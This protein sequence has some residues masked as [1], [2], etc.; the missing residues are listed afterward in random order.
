MM[1]FIK[2]SVL[3]LLA[4]LIAV[5]STG[6]SDEQTAP[7]LYKQFKAAAAKSGAVAA[8]DKYQLLWDDNAKCILLNDV[9]TGTVWSSMPYDFYKK[10]DK[11]G[12]ALVKLASPLIIEYFETAAF[13][14]KTAAAYP[15]CISYNT[16]LAQKIKNG[17]RV[18]YYFERLEIS[19]PL[20]YILTENGLEVRLRVNDIAENKNLV[21]KV[22]VLPYFASASPSDE[23]YL[24]IPSGSGAL[25]Y[26]DEGKRNVRKFSAEVFG[27]DLNSDENERLSESQ[28]VRLPFFGV[29]NG[30]DALCVILDKGK[31]TASVDAVAG[32]ADVGYSSAYTTWRIRGYDYV[33][34]Q[35]MHGVTSMVVQ[36]PYERLN[37]EYCSAHYIPLNGNNAGYLEMAQAYR[38]LTLKRSAVKKEP[39][40][41]LKMLGAVERQKLIF[42]VPKTD[43][44]ALTTAEQTESILAE[45]NNNAKGSVVAQLIGYGESGLDYGEIGGG[46]KPSGKLGSRSDFKKLNKNMD[47]LGVKLYFDFDLVNFSSSGSGASYYKD[48]AKTPNRLTLTKNEYLIDTFNKNTDISYRLLS[49]EKLSAMGE[50]AMESAGK[51]G[52]TGIS[53]KTL[54]AGAYSDYAQGE[55]FAKNGFESQVNGITSL[56]AKNKYGF[57]ADSANSYAVKNAD[58]VF[59]A[60]LFCDSSDALDISVPLYQMVYKGY[61]PLSGEAINLAVDPKKAFLQSV[62]TASGLCWSVCA[63]GGKTSGDNYNNA[64]YYS[65]FSLIKDD[66]KSLSSAAEELLNAVE[67]CTIADYIIVNDDVRITEFSNGVSVT[68]NFSN[69]EY[70]TEN[71]TVKPYDFAVNGVN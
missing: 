60:P 10:E 36:Y 4:S 42:G 61:V 59:A 55:Y 33:T 49:R 20:D 30:N 44:K 53:L 58:C 38:S 45:I 40:L 5:F 2:K 7:V 67:G 65:E 22:S 37:A 12:P 14:V 3:I 35:N 8:N 57:A 23:S 34:T 28:K 1:K 62:S 17:V 18:T 43:I 71:G 68:V 48:S 51:Y 25:I 39:Q 47:I 29:K 19:V 41:Y 69:E 63:E 9:A 64:P 26:T 15:E 52:F 27:E 56:L 31:E 11:S 21:T 13:Q 50:K 54:S 6:C 66:I 70:V 24:V 46:F 32:D 16:V